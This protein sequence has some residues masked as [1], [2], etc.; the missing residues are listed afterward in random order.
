[1][2]IIVTDLV[3]VMKQEKTFLKR[4]QVMMLFFAQLIQTI[5]QLAFQQLDEEVSAKLKE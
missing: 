3:K 1:M 4:E 5:V 2:D